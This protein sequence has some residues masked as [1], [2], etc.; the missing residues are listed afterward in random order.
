ML[1][2][3]SG[4][5]TAKPP[6][7]SRLPLTRESLSPSLPT[8]RHARRHITKGFFSFA[9]GGTSLRKQRQPELP[10]AMGTQAR[11][12]TAPRPGQVTNKQQSTS[13]SYVPPSFILITA[14][15]RRCQGHENH[16][17]ARVPLSPF[18]SCV[19]NPHPTS[20]PLHLV[21]VN[22]LWFPRL[23]LPFSA[24]V[25]ECGTSHGPFHSFLQPGI[26]SN[27]KVASLDPFRR[28]C[29]SAFNSATQVHQSTTLATLHAF[30]RDCA[31]VPSAS[32]TDCPSL[33]RPWTKKLVKQ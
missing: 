7:P 10:G 33:D 27:K 25:T 15:P 21:S 17:C 30:P 28:E 4:S 6:C 11:Q 31:I 24:F 1:I 32:L 23:A 29:S 9:L 5:T 14:A 13:K 2:Y 16:P 3:H 26:Q 8:R 12:G 18:F 20:A 19:S 22:P